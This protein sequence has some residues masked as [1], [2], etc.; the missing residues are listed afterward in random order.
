[1]TTDDGTAGHAGF[2]TDAL[3][4]LLA[5]NNYDVVYTCGPRGS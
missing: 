3:A 5:A 1:M 4:D 2:T